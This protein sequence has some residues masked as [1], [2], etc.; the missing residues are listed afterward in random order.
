ML[1]P[2]ISLTPEQIESFGEEI[3]SLY[4]ETKSK[5]GKEDLEIAET[6]DQLSKQFETFGRFLNGLGNPLTSIA[7]GVLLS[8]HYTFEFSQGHNILHGQYDAIPENTKFQS[9]T[10]KWENTMDEED[11]K[12][13]HHVVHHPFTNMVGKDND[14]GYLIFRASPSQ[15][16][17]PWH[18]FQVPG[19]LILPFISTAFYPWYVSTSRAIAENRN[20]FSSETYYP[21]FL[22]LFEYSFK[23]HLL[24]PLLSGPNFSWTLFGNVLG[25][26]LSN[27]HLEFILGNSHLG[28]EPYSYPERTSETKGEFYLRQVLTSANYTVPEWT[29]PVYGGINTH[30]EHHLFPDLPPN[31]LKEVQPKVQAICEKYE[32]PYFTGDF[33]LQSLKLFENVIHQS[34]PSK[35]EDPYPG[36]SLLLKPSELI[37]RVRN[38][39]FSAIEDIDTLRNSLTNPDTEKETF[40]KTKILSVEPAGNGVAIIVRIQIPKQWISRVWE[41]GSYISIRTKV[42]NQLY[43]RQYSLTR[44]W[45]GE[46]YYEICIKKIQNGIVS[47]YASESFKPGKE[48]ELVGNPKGEFVLRGIANE[49]VFF[50]AGAGITPL[51][52]IVRDLLRNHPTVPITLFSFNKTESEILYKKEL[53]ELSSF[54]QVRVIFVNEQPAASLPPSQPQLP[55]TSDLLTN[56][57]KSHLLNQPISP[58]EIPFLRQKSNAADCIFEVGRIRKELFS[59]IL[60]NHPNAH[61]YLCGPKPFMDITQSLTEEKGI[62][63]SK[64]HRESFTKE[65]KT[66]NPK[67]NSIFHNIIFKKSNLEISINEN[68]TI[69]EAIQKSGLRIPTG[70]LQ[71]MCKACSVKKLKGRI[72]NE[73]LE[74]PE[75]KTITT[76]G[77]YA[78]SDVELDL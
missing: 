53:M 28:S 44:P 14:Y 57:I 62:S 22:K 59:H 61:F 33:L 2:A 75:L 60:A 65:T 78:V 11:W 66:L 49:F 73:D 52:C 16:W 1:K 18:L 26:T 34:L 17:K 76:C 21:T 23:N 56:M 8:I 19:L 42:G 41:S 3:H 50:A 32:I 54:S 35:P 77:N 30:L 29:E 46:N 15:E 39:I 67:K 48:I 6:Y 24:Y 45:N 43:V 27:L 40:T 4:L 13:E 47:Q 58:S 25:K 37:D 9:A 31:R 20:V 5:V 55:S 51:I 70:C 64:I 69:L 10:W 12:F 68:T 63:K 74:S 36:L 38:G 72:E 71:G 7:G